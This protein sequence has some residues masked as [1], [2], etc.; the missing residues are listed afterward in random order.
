MIAIALH[1]KKINSQL[2][3][4][5]EKLNC[6]QLENNKILELVLLIQIV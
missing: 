3:V 4:I 2:E 5:K 6:F 1:R